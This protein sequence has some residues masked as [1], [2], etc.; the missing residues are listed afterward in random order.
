MEESLLS[1]VMKVLGQLHKECQ[2]DFYCAFRLKYS[3]KPWT[4]CKGLGAIA[5]EHY[6][7]Y[8]LL[9]RSP[10]FVMAQ[11]L[12][13]NDQLP[14]TTSMSI[15]RLQSSLEPKAVTGVLLFRK[16]IREALLKLIQEGAPVAASRTSIN[17]KLLQELGVQLLGFIRSKSD[18]HW[19]KVESYTKEE[20]PV[21]LDAYS[22]GDLKVVIPSTIEQPN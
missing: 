15:N 10:L 11:Y 6:L 8:D 16:K 12:D 3:R 4:F 17:A 9:H 5:E 7:K 22:R 1:S 18:T 2:T 14:N 21:F 20:C 13:D 19:A